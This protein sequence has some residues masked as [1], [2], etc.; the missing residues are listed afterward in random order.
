MLEA[1]EKLPQ[2]EIF[3]IP[4][5]LE[6]CPMPEVL[7]KP[8]WVNLFE[9]GG[10]EKLRKALRLRA[11][12]L[13]LRSRSTRK[14]GDLTGIY[15]AQGINA[16]GTQYAGTVLISR[17]Q[18]TYDVTWKVETDRFHAEGTLNKN[19]FVVTGDFNFTY[20]VRRDGT[21][22]GKWDRNA[23]ETLKLVPSN[24]RFIKSP[25]GKFGRIRKH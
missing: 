15:A 23:T 9:V 17:S 19:R 10:Y 1:A 13:G 6:N 2:G 25:I 4:V 18:K 20:L 8:Q 21:L 3:V 14:I 22:F 5:R 24:S 16:D 7:K 11:K 12:A